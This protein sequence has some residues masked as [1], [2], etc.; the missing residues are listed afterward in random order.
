MSQLVASL[1]LVVSSY[2]A[3]PPG[4]A[5]FHFGTLAGVSILFMGWQYEHTIWDY[6]DR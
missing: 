3:D 5:A 2:R 1:P 4:V 6:Y